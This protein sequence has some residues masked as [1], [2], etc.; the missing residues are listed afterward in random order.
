M[1]I[2]NPQPK[3]NAPI[4]KTFSLKPDVEVKG[5]RALTEICSFFKEIVNNHDLCQLIKM[6]Q[7]NEVE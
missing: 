6:L 3:L 1:G 4:F 7:L 5:F 2:V